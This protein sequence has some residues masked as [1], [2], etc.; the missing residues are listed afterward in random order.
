L[1]GKTRLSRRWR[2]SRARRRTFRPFF[3][4]FEDRLVPTTLSIPNIATP[5]LRGATVSVPVNVDTLFSTDDPTFN[6]QQGLNGAGLI[7]WFDPNVLSVNPS[8]DITL[9]TVG[10]PSTP[11]NGFSDANPNG[12]LV[13]ANSVEPGQ[14]VISFTAPS[15]PSLLLTGTGGGSLAIINF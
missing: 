8:T 11:G 5:A 7:L 14:L 3:E 4:Q 6:S 9:G 12:W 13:S 1:N 2:L 15:S 10:D